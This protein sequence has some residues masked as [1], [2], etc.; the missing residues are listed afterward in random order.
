[1]TYYR[2]PYGDFGPSAKVGAQIGHTPL[3]WVVDPDDWKL[4]GADT[5][6]TR[7]HDQLTPRAVVLVHDGGGDR[8]QTVQALEKLIP[9]LIGEGWTF[10][11]PETTI[12]AK[13]LPGAPSSAT[14]PSASASPSPS[15]S[16]SVS[17]SAPDASGG[18]GTPSV[19][20]SVTPSVGPSVAPSVAP[21]AG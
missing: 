2:A 9:R 10:D 6:A 17:A 12:A 3:G 7:I 1:V 16:P 15:V 20:P 13:P 14:A 5:I 19:A 18:S 21:T 8:K 4:P 11:F